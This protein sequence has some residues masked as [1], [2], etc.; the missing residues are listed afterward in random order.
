MVCYYYRFEPHLCIIINVMVAIII[1]NIFSVIMTIGII[2]I[3]TIDIARALLI[4][5]T[6]GYAMAM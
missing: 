2:A 4:Q 1:I 3:I 6:L 5:F